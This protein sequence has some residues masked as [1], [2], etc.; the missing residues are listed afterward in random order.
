MKKITLLSFAATLA[1]ASEPTVLSKVTVEGTADTSAITNLSPATQHAGDAASLLADVPGVSLYTNGSTASLPVIHGMADDR[2]KIDIDGMTITA[3]CPNHMNPALSYMD[4]SKIASMD[5]MAGITPVSLGGDSIG[6]T[7]AVKSKEPVFAKNPNEVIIT[8]DTGAFYR[9]NGHARGASLNADVANDTLSVRYSGFMEKTENYRDGNGRIVKGTLAQQHNHALTVAYK[10]NEDNILSLKATK[11]YV[12]FAGFPNEYMDMLNNTA[13]NF[14]ASY[15]GKVGKVRLDA[16]AYQQKTDH[17]MNKILTERTG[18]MPMYTQ[19]KERG[20]NLKATIPLSDAQTLK[21]GTD[22]DHYSLNDWWPAA[23]ATVG[24]MGPNTFWNINNGHRDRLGAYIETVSQWSE[25]LSSNIGIR[26]DRV[27]MN[28]G[29]VVGYNTL[30]TP[31]A[32]DPKDAS[33]F[34]ALNHQKTDKNYDVTAT[35]KY[36]YSNTSDIEVGF[37]RKTRSPNIYER[38]AWAGGYGSN[39]LTSGPIAMDMAM[40]NWFGDGNGYVGNIN[41]RPEIAHTFSATFALHDS[42]QKEWGIKLTPYYTKVHDY[43]DVT[44][45]GTATAGGYSGIRLL[46]F[47]NT[48]AHLFGADVSGYAN[49]WDNASY[50][51]GTLKSVIG[52]TRGMR[53]NGGS[54]YHIMP[55]HAKVSLDHRM[56][57][58]NSGIDIQGVGAKDSV[59]TLRKEPLTPGYALIDLRTGYQI[60]KNIQWDVAVTNLLDK[61]Y[62]LPLGGVDVLNYAKTTYTPLQGMGRSFNTALTIKF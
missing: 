62:A 17:Y 60:S 16:N 32:N 48:D 50:G 37:A 28:T 47:T 25:K 27:S 33:G 61:G 31:M 21:L 41:L 52:Y 42:T 56:G 11:T 57:G 40:V 3:A 24:G 55:L 29:N 8:G 54:L 5:V 23:T 7:I 10:I 46:Q 1:L 38:Y 18:N 39:P 35:T 45:L 9:S 44:V 14:N 30:A 34:N 36:E 12:D 59:D 4:A 43:I 15:K 22:Y 20:Y 6:G 19:A 13:T 51:T 58:W 2:V 26:T 49:V 53:D